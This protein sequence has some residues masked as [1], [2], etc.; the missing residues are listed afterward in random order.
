MFNFETAFVYC[1][2]WW[3]DDRSVCAGCF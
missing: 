3:V 2:C 1:T